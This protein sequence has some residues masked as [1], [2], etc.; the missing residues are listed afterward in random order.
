M[1]NL[2]K[3]Y[4]TG[5]TATGLQTTLTDNLY[6]NTATGRTA[7]NDATTGQEWADDSS[8]T[9]QKTHNFF[10]DN[11]V[12]TKLY[13]RTGD[14]ISAGPVA[15]YPGHTLIVTENTTLTIQANNCNVCPGAKIVVE[16]GAT[17]VVAGGD[18]QTNAKPV[19]RMNLFGEIINYGTLICESK[20]VLARGS[21]FINASNALGANGAVIIKNKTKDANGTALTKGNYVLAEMLELM[22]SLPTRLYQE[23][24]IKEYW[25]TLTS[26]VP[27]AG[28]T[29]TA[30]SLP[31]NNSGTEG[32]Q[33]GTQ[34]DGS[35]TQ[36]GN[37]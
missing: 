5:A 27:I 13:T 18:C 24:Q 1:S 6:Q 33:D 32:T 36:T 37:A 19:G 15:I 28:S 26:Q 4:A 25:T 16:A 34:D 10:A 29:D 17:L 12:L 11:N 9:G 31:D 21:E 35:A 30:Q 7:L 14:F 23:V 3:R 22:N 8:G 20:F 2:G